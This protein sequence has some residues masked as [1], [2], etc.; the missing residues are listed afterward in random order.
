MGNMSYCRF[1]NTA[2]DLKDC[3]DAIE[4]GETQELSNREIEGL[5][6]LLRS[7]ESIFQ[8]KEDIES[9]IE[10]WEESDVLPF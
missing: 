8:M 1:E 2:R 9:I 3:V 10:S 4:N 6:D 7:C 5:E